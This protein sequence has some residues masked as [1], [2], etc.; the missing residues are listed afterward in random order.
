MFL[1]RK[2]F[3]DRVPWLI[4]HVGVKMPKQ[5]IQ[6]LIHIT[7]LTFVALEQI[8]AIDKMVLVMKKSRKPKSHAVDR[9]YE[10]DEKE[11]SNEEKKAFKNDEPERERFNNFTE[12]QTQEFGLSDYIRKFQHNKVVEVCLLVFDD[13]E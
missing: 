11:D 5:Y 13:F 7:D 6:N 9:G 8:V 3:L 2:Q 1:D 4:Q 10:G 12:L